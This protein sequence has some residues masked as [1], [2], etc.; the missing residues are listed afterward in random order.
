MHRVEDIVVTEAEFSVHP[1]RYA[2]GQY[3]VKVV[4][5]GSGL[6]RR[7]DYLLCAL[8]CRWTHREHGYVCSPS[9]VLKFRRLFADGWTATIFGKLVE[10]TS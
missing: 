4:S 7:A 2:K 6:K 8:N 3:L 1:A 10:P 9:K 5:D